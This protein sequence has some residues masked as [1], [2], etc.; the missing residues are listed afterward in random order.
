MARAFAGLGT[1]LGDRTANLQRAIGLIRERATVT[2]VSPVYETEPVGYADQPWFLNC[3][4]ELDTPLPPHNLWDAL[5]S[6]ERAMGKATPFPNGPRVID[7][8]LLLYD[9]LVIDEPGLQV[10]HPRMHERRFVLAPLA[11]VAP[12][13]VHAALRRT[14]ASLL[15]AAPER[16]QVRLFGEGDS[17]GV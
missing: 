9:D 15:E 13:L 6:V 8:D 3:V 16:E 11:D 1:N 14:V 2:T 7:A 5:Q 10:P 17:A 4:V 12:A